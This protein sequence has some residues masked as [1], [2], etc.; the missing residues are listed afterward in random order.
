MDIQSRHIRAVE[1]DANAQVLTIE[2]KNGSRYSYHGVPADVHQ[3]MVDAKSVG[4]HFHRF[5]R[6]K[7][8]EQKI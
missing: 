1:Y 6:G 7:H 2:F 4:G 8:V 5:V 3:Q